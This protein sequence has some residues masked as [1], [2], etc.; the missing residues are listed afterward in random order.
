MTSSRFSGR[1]IGALATRTA[2][3]S[4]LVLGAVGL[5]SAPAQ[6]AVTGFG[7]AVGVLQTVTVT[8]VT[9][10][11]VGQST[12]TVTP[13]I[14]GVAQ[15][16]TSGTLQ[17][18]TLTFQW[19]PANVGAA[20]FSMSD[21]TT[22]SIIPA[23]SITQVTTTTIISTPNTAPLNQAVRVNITVQSASPSTYTPTGQVVVRN[24]NG[25][26]LSTMGLTPGPGVG[27]SFAYYWWTPT[28]AGTF[29]FVATYNG[30]SNATTSVSPQ[31]TV[32]ATPSG[33][34]ISLSAPATMT[35]GVPVQLTATV[36]PSGTQGSVGFTVNG[37]PISASV[38]L[39]AQGQA[40]FT[41]TP[42]AAG[43]ITLG[44]S[45]M[46]SQGGSGSTSERVTVVAG[47]AAKDTISLTQPGVGPWNPNGVYTVP[48]GTTFTFQASTQS[49]SP[50]TLSDTGPCQVNGLTLTV[51]VGSGQCNLVAS[52][53]GGPG[54]A[55]NQQGYT[56]VASP[57]TQALTFQPPASS[58]VNR[59]R[60][61]RLEANGG[62]DTNAGQAVNWRAINSGGVCRVTFPAN[63]SVIVRTTGAGTCQIRGIAQA[64]PGQWNR[65][66]V[67]YTYR[68]R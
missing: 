35:Q 7:G 27:Q 14:N 63:G 6:A 58:R 68:V 32:I 66:V 60:N 3:A 11:G 57:G 64:V 46:T 24:A 8:D 53:P 9:T 25:A 43:Q 40:S 16:S 50:V 42:T 67:N 1:R 15:A 28:A 2:A 20:T 10:S 37:Q 41:W 34:T 51:D 62:S 22:T 19:T 61:I 21:C 5:A 29:F 47:A 56:V 26:V 55:A 54:Y 36:F 49:G 30:D 45:Y 44:A 13:T 17:G 4:A 39:N 52:S 65:M 12:C 59:G 33:N 31:D 23:A 48:N 18:T 38:P